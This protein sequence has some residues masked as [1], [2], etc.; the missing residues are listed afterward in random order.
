MAGSLASG[1]D[2]FEQVQTQLR[3][4]EQMVNETHHAYHQL[5]ARMNEA[6]L[7]LEQVKMK[8]QYLVD[9]IHERYMLDLREISS[10]YAALEFDVAAM[11]TES[12]ALKP[13]AHFTVI[14][15]L[16][17]YLFGKTILGTK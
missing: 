12:S 7:R 10:Q 5:Q 1:R 2:A 6:T 9:Q 14:E 15:K 4:Q 17:P 3:A 8:E 11:E 16:R 13:P